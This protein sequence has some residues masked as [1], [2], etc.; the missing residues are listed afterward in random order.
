M[1]QLEETWSIMNWSTFSALANIRI[2]K[3]RTGALGQPANPWPSISRTQTENGDQAV[4][5]GK[6]LIHPTPGRA[7]WRVISKDPADTTDSKGKELKK[8]FAENNEGES[9]CC[10][11]MREVPVWFSS[12]DHDLFFKN[13]PKVKVNILKSII[14]TRNCYS[15]DQLDFVFSIV[16]T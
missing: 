2:Y 4:H 7:I 15:N 1:E 13:I 10:H 9:E 8:I 16:S 12:L 3:S 5:V 11:L 6:Q 14:S